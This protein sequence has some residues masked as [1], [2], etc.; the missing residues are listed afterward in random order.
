MNDLW[1]AWKVALV[2]AVTAFVGLLVAGGVTG[3]M[4]SGNPEKAGE[5]FG[6]RRHDLEHARNAEYVTK[7]QH[8][9]DAMHPS[10]MNHDAVEKASLETIFALRLDQ[11]NARAARHHS[12]EGRP[13]TGLRRHRQRVAAEQS[14]QQR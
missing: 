3:A 4:S 13:V 14:A 12:I 7:P 8:L 5:H 9:L 10:L 1:P 6:P 2:T 11:R